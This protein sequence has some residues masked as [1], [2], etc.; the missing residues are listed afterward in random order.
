MFLLYAIAFYALL[1]GLRYLLMFLH[2]KKEKFQYAEYTLK[3]SREV[4]DYI[5]RVFQ[6]AIQELTP[7]GFKPCSYRQVKPISKIQPSTVWS[8][9]FYHPSHKTYAE[10]DLRL[11]I[12]AVQLL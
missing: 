9:L 8:L 7:L 10:V 4:P 5:Q 6:S 1:F 3:P 11:L 2:L 12:E